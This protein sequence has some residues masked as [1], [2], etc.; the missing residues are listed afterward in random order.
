MR[1]YEKRDMQGTQKQKAKAQRR[2]KKKRRKG[3]QE[4]INELKIN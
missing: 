4:Y 2:K 1:W 3:E